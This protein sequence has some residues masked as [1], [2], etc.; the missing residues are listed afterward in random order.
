MI[1]F[2]LQLTVLQLNLFRLK[3][4]MLSILKIWSIMQFNAKEKTFGTIIFI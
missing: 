2:N 1:Q 3:W 4:E